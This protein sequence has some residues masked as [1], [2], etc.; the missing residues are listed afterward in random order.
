MKAGYHPDL[1]LH[2]RGG[3]ERKGRETQRGN[4]LQFMRQIKRDYRPIFLINVDVNFFLSSLQEI[5]I[6]VFLERERKGERES[7]M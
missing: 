2:F 4:A 6:I 1:Y 3:G 5:F 7:S